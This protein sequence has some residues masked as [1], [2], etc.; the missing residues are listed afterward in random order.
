M[1]TAT[2]PREEDRVQKSQRK[3][4]D[5]LIQ[6][7]SQ[8]EVEIGRLNRELDESTKGIL[9]R[10]YLHKF[11][12]REISF[13][14][15]WGLRYFVLQGTTI[16]YY[17]DDRDLRPRRT[18]D[19]AGCLLQEEGTKKGG[20]FHVF[21]IFWPTSDDPETAGNLL[22]RLSTEHKGEAAQWVAMLRQACHIETDET[23]P[24][25]FLDDRITGLIT[26]PGAVATVD[27]VSCIS[28]NGAPS[29]EEEWSN[30]PID[31]DMTH[32]DELSA[33]TMKR[34]ISSTE[35]LKKST[36][37]QNI[38]FRGS[39][40]PSSSG[41]HLLKVKPPSSPAKAAAPTGGLNRK[42]PASKP[43]HI[44]SNPSPLSSDVRPGEQNY[45]GFFNLV[46]E[47]LSYYPII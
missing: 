2:S 11:R 4:M 25:P 44:E 10:G 6:Q 17:I 8:L 39:L 33:E 24:E 18:I 14:S 42:Y 5:M 15:K 31:G 47:I 28:N 30:S 9:M 37:R 1:A 27:T 32:D 19:L 7:N 22:L 38:R 46:R 16:S 45:R 12:D 43:I 23:E 36:S 26:S 3:L 40:K 20:L 13:A 34:V 41:R 29:V 21:S 35:I